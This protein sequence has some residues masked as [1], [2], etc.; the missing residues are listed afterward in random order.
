MRDGETRL[1]FSPNTS[2]DASRHFRSHS[3]KILPQCHVLQYAITHTLGA[4][5]KAVSYKG[6]QSGS[7]SFDRVLT[8]RENIMLMEERE[9]EKKAKAREKEERKLACEEIRRRN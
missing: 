3:F 6:K 1:N 8:S 7:K 4:K 5:F 9:K 2:H